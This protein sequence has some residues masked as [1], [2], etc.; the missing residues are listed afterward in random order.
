MR[1]S[2]PKGFLF[3]VEPQAAGRGTSAHVLVLAQK[4]QS[5]FLHK[6]RLLGAA[7]SKSFLDLSCATRRT[8]P[9]PT[10]NWLATARQ[11]APWARSSATLLA[12]TGF[13]GRPI[14][15]PRARAAAM[16]DRTRSRISSRFQ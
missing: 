13:R 15:A 5:G 12:S 1:L 9:M 3:D 16:P 6:T 7:T 11:E 10:P 14:R 8:V 2:G 4:F